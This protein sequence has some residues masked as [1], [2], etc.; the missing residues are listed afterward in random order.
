MSIV[1]AA[2][3]KKTMNLPAIANDVI[4]NLVEVSVD[5]LNLFAGAG[6]I[7]NMSGTAGTKTLSLSSEKRGALMLVVRAAYYGFYKDLTGKTVGEVSF[8]PTD[9]LSN[10]N[11]LNTIQLAA[12]R[13]SPTS[14]A[15][16]AAPE[17]N[18]RRG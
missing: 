7:S 16:G 6:T 12:A 3:V 2:F 10:T 11:V 4:E 13:L 1:D 14:G 5:V 8:S 17:I 15:T 9:L 18:V